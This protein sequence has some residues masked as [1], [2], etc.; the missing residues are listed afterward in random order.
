[1][2][3][4]QSEAQQYISGNKLSPDELDQDLQYVIINPDIGTARLG[5]ATRTADGLGTLVGPGIFLDVPR[6]VTFSLLGV[7]GGMGGTAVVSGK[8]QFGNAISE[9]LGFATAAGGGTA[10]GTQV[11]SR[12]GTATFTIAGLGGTAIGSAYL[13]YPVGDVAMVIGLPAKLGA[14]A[15]LKRVTWND[16]GI[17]KGISVGTGGTIGTAVA[18]TALSSVTLTGLGGFATADSFTFIYRST[19]V[20]EAQVFTT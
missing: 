17:S 15:D 19:F 11:F 8:D 7:A 4:K 14:A 10:Q 2:A 18:G 16:A 3:L 5:T 20:A 9:S 13:G 12:V 6:T 1:M